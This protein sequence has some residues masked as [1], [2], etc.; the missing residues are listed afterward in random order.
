M[1]WMSSWNTPATRRRCSPRPAR[2][3]AAA[4]DQ[5]SNNRAPPARR[6]RSPAAP[7]R[8]GASSP[9]R[10]HVQQ[11]WR[12]RDEHPAKVDAQHHLAQLPP[13]ATRRP[14]RPVRRPATSRAPR[15]RCRAAKAPAP[16]PIA[17]SAAW[18]R[19]SAST[20]IQRLFSIGSSP[21]IAKCNAMAPKTQPTNRE[22]RI[23]IMGR[24]AKR[25]CDSRHGRSCA[26]HLP[27]RPSG[28]ANARLSVG[29]WPAQGRP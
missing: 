27:H 1:I 10:Q 9:E 29:R 26:G 8:G 16:M 4:G 20:M 2:G 24:Y 19:D 12:Q 25:P 11:V 21:T 3:A 18:P 14:R 23:W 28:C 15:G 13:A 17:S 7:A 6:R 22:E 5:A